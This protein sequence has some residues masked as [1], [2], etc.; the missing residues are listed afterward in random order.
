VAN[1]EGIAEKAG[2]PK[3]ARLYIYVFVILAALTDA[4][5]EDPEASLSPSGRVWH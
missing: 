2:L 1:H 3:I 4:S 5:R